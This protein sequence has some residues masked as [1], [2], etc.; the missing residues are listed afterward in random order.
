MPVPKRRQSQGGMKSLAALPSK[1]LR[2]LDIDF[3]FQKTRLL[4]LWGFA[5]TVV[6]IGMMTEPRPASWFDLINIFE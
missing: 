6:L 5:P 1:A 2:L 3:L 4:L